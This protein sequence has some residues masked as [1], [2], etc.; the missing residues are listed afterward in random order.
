MKIKV[1]DLI[2]KCMILL[3]L[4]TLFSS[5]AL[6]SPINRAII[7]TISI[8]L[9]IVAFNKAT[10]FM[11]ICVVALAIVTI[12]S[13]V[14][15]VWPIETIN[16]LFYFPIWVLMLNLF[17]DKY[18]SFVTA[19]KNNVNWMKVICIAWNIAV[20]ISLPFKSSYSD[21]AFCS[22][23]GA[24]HRFAT[25]A[26]LVLCV[27]AL[28]AKITES[29]KYLLFAVLPFLTILLTGAR[30]YMIVAAIAVV[31][32]YYSFA[33]SKYSFY[34][35]IIPALILGVYLVMNSSVMTERTAEMDRLIT[36]FGDDR[37][38]ALT[39]GRSVWWETDMKYFFRSSIVNQIFGNGF[40]FIRYINTVYYGQNIW[41]HNDYVMLLGTTGYISLIL[42][43]VCYFRISHYVTKKSNTNRKKFLV[44]G[45]HIMNFVNAMF[46]MLYTYLC[47]TFAMIFL[48][49]V[50]FD[51]ENF[52]PMVSERNLINKES[53]EKL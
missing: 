46:N 40:H 36:Y 52:K 44:V 4:T 17:V 19:I 26:L 23:A 24:Q 3:A 14:Q 53:I 2:I 6:I 25:C 12:Y 18:Q 9:V 22:F 47:A 15:T 48:L 28:I 8:L 38:R 32:I 5:S 16:E 13:L 11:V 10:K 49:M 42:Y 31:C 27:S 51:D 41:A 33:K 20:V 43:F 37:L 29:K 35:L 7:A 50:F 45:F 34:I 30:T 1:H 21:A 39:S